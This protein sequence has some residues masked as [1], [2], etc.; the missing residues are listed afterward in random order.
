MN[1]RREILMKNGRPALIRSATG[2]DSLELF[3]FSQKTHGESNFLTTYPDEITY[4]PKEEAAL[5][6]LWLREPGETELCAV[7]EGRIVGSAGVHAIR[8]RDKMRLRA[9]LGISVEKA[10]WGLGLGRALM[11]SC[12]D[13]ARRGGYR[14][15]ELQVVADN[16]RAISLYQSLGFVEFGRNPRGFSPREGGWQELLSMRLELD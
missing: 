9:E 7:V 3:H 16:R 15:L 12:L 14:Q 5:Y 2:A 8:R 4:H 6:E 10:H 11:E 13:C 1:Y